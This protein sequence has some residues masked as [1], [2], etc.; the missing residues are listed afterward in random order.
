MEFI[1]N[2]GIIGTLSLL[3][4]LLGFFLD[5]DPSNPTILTTISEVVIM[6]YVISP[7][8]AIVYLPVYYLII[9]LKGNWKW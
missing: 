6:A 1:K 8:V 4:S 5:T 9:I 7:F 2:L 3:I